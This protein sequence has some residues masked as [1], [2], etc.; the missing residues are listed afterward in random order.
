M[1][2]TVLHPG[3]MG[4]AIARTI[5]SSGSRV[6]Y[7]PDGRSKDTIRRAESANLD[8]YSMREA[9]ENSDII[10]SVCPPHAAESVAASVMEHG[11][12]GTF[13][14]ANAVSPQRTLRI[15]EAVHGAGGT[16]VDGGIVGGPPKAKGE[17]YIYLSGSE[18]DS[19]ASLFSGGLIA[20][21]IVSDRIGDASAL[22]MCYAA[23]TKGST[24]M[25]LAITAAAES[26]GVREKLFAQWE[27]EGSGLDE[28]VTRRAERV[29]LK[30][31]RWIYE[32][33]EIADTLGSVDLPDGFHRSA[34]DI[35]RRLED[36]R[37]GDGELSEFKDVLDAL[38][39]KKV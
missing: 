36:L 10:V 21:E 13:V 38:T 26:L 39:G 1:I 7:V 37:P 14:D 27:R 23:Y 20:P 29:P 32:M 6:Q 15:S 11:F 12:N 2:V 35:Y 8:P 17:C 9:V 34:A 28:A 5:S 4:V 3:A 16:F 24:A 18:A 25:L 31:W 33:E 22:K 19:V 30:A